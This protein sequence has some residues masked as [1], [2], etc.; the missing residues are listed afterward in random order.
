MQ[1]NLDSI[2]VTVSSSL[3]SEASYCIWGMINLPFA[4]FVDIQRHVS[5]DSSGTKLVAFR[6]C[7]NQRI[8]Q[9]IVFCFEFKYTFVAM[10]PTL[11]Q[12]MRADRHRNQ[13]E[14]IDH[15]KAH[16]N[17]SFFRSKENMESTARINI[18]AGSLIFR[19]SWCSRCRKRRRC[20]TPKLPLSDVPGNLAM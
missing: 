17:A 9:N 1:Y 4:S 3:F 6:S 12:I 10:R 14:T 11:L 7:C 16:F 19:C 8:F 15:N 2:W 20:G 18:N 5:T 13:Y